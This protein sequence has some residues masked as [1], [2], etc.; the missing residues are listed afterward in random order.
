[1][2]KMETDTYTKYLEQIE[3]QKPSRLER[4]AETMRSLSHKMAMIP[5]VNF[6]LNS[7]KSPFAFLLSGAAALFDFIGSVSHGRYKEGVKKLVSGGVDMAV[8]GAMAVTG[9]GAL[10]AASVWW[11]AS[12]FSSIAT[13]DTL[14]ELLRKGTK[15]LL[16]A[17]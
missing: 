5:I 15:S 8:V 16:D 7:G 3:N 1:M 17:L 6:F 9:L 10:G 11:V 12:A 14:P 4:V 2:R 13:G